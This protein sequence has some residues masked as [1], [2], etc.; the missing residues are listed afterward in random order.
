[1]PELFL[2]GTEQ[3]TLIVATV[4]EYLRHAFNIDLQ[5]NGGADIFMYNSSVCLVPLIACEQL[6]CSPR[7]TT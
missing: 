2:Q 7:S 6:Y 3:V 1:M 5:L 4:P